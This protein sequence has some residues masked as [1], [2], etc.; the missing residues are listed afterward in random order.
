MESIFI[1]T[2]T[3]I[4]GLFLGYYARQM[5]AK[6][7]AGTIEKVLAR[8]IQKA[9]IEAQKILND[10]DEKAQRF[11]ESTSKISSKGIKN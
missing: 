9:K 10:A 3:L 4:F 11:L 5:I 8:K 1:G 6:K 7:R 2:V